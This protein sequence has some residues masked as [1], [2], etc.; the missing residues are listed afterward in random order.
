MS[1]VAKAM[2]CS[3]AMDQLIPTLKT[4]V[5]FHLIKVAE[6]LTS[7]KPDYQLV[8][9]SIETL[10]SLDLN[11][12]ALQNTKIKWGPYF[13][14]SASEI[15]QIEIQTNFQH[16]D[17]LDISNKLRMLN[18]PFIRNHL[19][20]LLQFHVSQMAW[21]FN[22]TLWKSEVTTLSKI[23]TIISQRSQII[24][25]EPQQ[26][27]P[28]IQLPNFFYVKVVNQPLEETQAKA[29]VVNVECQGL[30]GSQLH[31][32]MKGKI[33]NEFKSINLQD[34]EVKFI[35]PK[36]N[37]PA[38]L[39]VADNQMLKLRELVFNS[40]KMAEKEGLSSVAFPV[41]RNG[42][43]LGAVEK[44]PKEV[45]YEILVG[46][47][48]YVESSS[49]IVK[50]IFISIPKDVALTNIFQELILNS[51]PSYERSLRLNLRETNLSGEGFVIHPNIMGHK[52]KIEDSPIYRDLLLPWN[53]ER[54]SDIYAPIPLGLLDGKKNFSS[55]TV[56]VLNMPIKMPGTDVRVPVELKQFYEFLQRILDHE[57][58]INPDY[59]DF[60]AYLTV[61]QSPVQENKTHRQSGIHID[62]V[63]GARY[64]V[65]LPPEHTYSASDTLGTIFYPQPFNLKG[66][67]L[68]KVF[69]HD[70]LWDQHDP[71]VAMVT[72]DYV[73]YFWNSYSVH[74]AQKSSVF[75]P[76]RTFIRVEFSK[77]IYDS[78]GDTRNPLFKYDWQ[79]TYRPIPS[80]ITAKKN[81]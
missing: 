60:F 41:M 33:P 43:A 58:K 55:S 7:K 3:L 54:M 32:L 39:L 34:G 80:E 51:K 18:V 47:S 61:D 17:L 2:T 62:G 8:R 79:Q 66:L 35:P 31:S 63:Q 65:K 48:K 13:R 81:E 24:K 67:N 10:S 28:E 59:K 44:T 49:G 53:V 12:S 19:D 25:M 52:D 77:K 57:I 1:N 29:Q 30:C 38:L 73:I 42:Y 50:E 76:R 20:D 74:E 21:V 78:H 5:D 69:I 56:S 16:S 46:V 15:L 4:D 68:E 45:A 72:E 9:S 64:P 27:W 75:I 23:K 22:R 26:D 71:Q 70:L 11:E 37:V 36:A 40:L 14:R 6:F